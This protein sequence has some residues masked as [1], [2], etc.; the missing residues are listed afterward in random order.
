MESVV[1]KTFAISIDNHLKKVEEENQEAKKKN[2]PTTSAQ[3]TAPE[4]QL[5]RVNSGTS[6]WKFDSLLW[7]KENRC[8]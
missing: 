4:H 1:L 8:K 2:N 6:L 7:I 3:I 5:R